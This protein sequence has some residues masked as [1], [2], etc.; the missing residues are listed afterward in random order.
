MLLERIR[1]SVGHFV[2]HWY[3]AVPEQSISS[4]TYLPFL[5]NS[6]VGV[7]FA[8]LGPHLWPMQVPRPGVESEL[9]LLAYTTATAT[10]DPSHV[11]TYTA[12]HGKAGSLTH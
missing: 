3:P 8:F 10:Q 5:P 12:A 4:E 9:Q 1:S 11:C 7:F 2:S 6:C